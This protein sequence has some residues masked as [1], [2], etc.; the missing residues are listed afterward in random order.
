M[1]VIGAL[2]LIFGAMAIVASAN[3]RLP[4]VMAAMFGQIPPAAPP[5]GSLQLGSS[6]TNAGSF[7]S[8]PGQSVGVGVG[9]PGDTGWTPGAPVA[10]PDNV[11]VSP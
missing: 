5:L 9:G 10:A 6:Q 4:I 8:D 2:L 7:F 11:Q 3:G 1:G